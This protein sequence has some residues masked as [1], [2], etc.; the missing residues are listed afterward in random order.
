ML[1]E[2]SQ[3]RQQ[4]L[5]DREGELTELKRQ[6]REVLSCLGERPCCLPQ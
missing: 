1:E 3:R 4:K 6:R 5:E 2:K